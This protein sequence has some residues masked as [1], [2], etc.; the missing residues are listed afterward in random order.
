[1][2]HI[3]Y[4]IAVWKR[5]FVACLYVLFICVSVWKKSGKLFRKW[6]RSEGSDSLR[7]EVCEHGVQQ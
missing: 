1:M 5:C 4:Y 6:V 2:Y 7:K 3:V